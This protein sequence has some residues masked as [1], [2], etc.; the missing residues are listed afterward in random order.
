[1]SQEKTSLCLVYVRRRRGFSLSS[2]PEFNS[3]ENSILACPS[4]TWK[5]MNSYVGLTC[6]SQN[7]LKPRCGPSNKL[8]QK[9]NGK[10]YAGLQK[11]EYILSFF[12]IIASC[13]SLEENLQVGLNNVKK[14]AIHIEVHI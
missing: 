5:Q 4:S 8:M 10:R 7:M 2:F 6:I 11:W 14:A 1:M 3:S 12:C 9:S 13:L